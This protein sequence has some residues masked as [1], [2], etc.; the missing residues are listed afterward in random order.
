MYSTAKLDKLSI[1][2]S[3]KKKKKEKL[4]E[5]RVSVWGDGPFAELIT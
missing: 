1:V 5:Y 3:T 2:A 4:N